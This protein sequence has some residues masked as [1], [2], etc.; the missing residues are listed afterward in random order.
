[1]DY[2]ESRFSTIFRDPV[3]L[4]KL[5]LVSGSNTANRVTTVLFG[6]QPTP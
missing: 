1:M 5:K 3:L 6:Q 4:V 2:L